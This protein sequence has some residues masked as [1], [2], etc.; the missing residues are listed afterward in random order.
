MAQLLT[1][2]SVTEILVFLVL[3]AL[4]VKGVITFC[5]W[6]IDRLRKFFRKENEDDLDKQKIDQL[7]ENQNKL[8]ENMKKLSDKID[9]LIESDKAD[10]KSYITE[11]HHYFVYDQKWIDDHS[12]DCLEK[13]FKHYEQE[14]GNSF[15]G[16]LMSEI[17]ALPKRSPQR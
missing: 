1:T 5:D 8:I 10:I 4:G 17:R 16:G 2:Y 6:A 11:K 15:V 9:M 14:G 13:R 7:S 12:L 3:F